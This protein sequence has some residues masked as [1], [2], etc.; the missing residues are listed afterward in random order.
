MGITFR[1]AIAAVAVSV[2]TSGCMPLTQVEDSVAQTDT[3]PSPRE[4][5]L[6]VAMTTDDATRRAYENRCDRQLDGVVH[7]T[8]SHHPFPA[9]E[10]MNRDTVIE[11]LKTHPE[12]DG[13][14]VM[15]LASLD[16]MRG[17]LSTG[18]VAVRELNVMDQPG[19]TWNYQPD[20]SRQL[21]EHPT[22][23][24]QNSLYTMPDAA[25]VL[26]VMARS[27]ID[28]KLTSLARSH[29]KALRRSLLESGWL[30]R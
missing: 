20:P 1:S 19:L 17:Q 21:P 6:L 2:I 28:G 15:Q 23:L 3:A 27:N 26:T 10:A 18:G 29:C 22:A 14:A 13:V 11:W 25:L 30:S 9:L 12:I 16:E 4:H 8:A 5:I 7:V 24:T